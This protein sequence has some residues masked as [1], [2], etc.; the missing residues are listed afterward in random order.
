MGNRAVITTSKVYDPANSTQIGVYLH[1]YGDVKQVA[2][3]LKYCELKGFRTP[4]RDDYGWARL[5]QVIGNHIGGGLS[6]GIGPCCKLD[7]DNGDNGTYLISGWE[8]VGR[9]YISDNDCHGGDLTQMLIEIDKS[10]PEKEQFGKEFFEAEEVPVSELKVGDVVYFGDAVYEKYEK[11]TVVGIG[12]ENINSWMQT[13]GVPYVD[14][15]ADAN[16]DYSKNGNNYIRTATAR[17]VD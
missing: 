1:W 8:I 6:I 16:G 12:K 10:Q 15:Y 4:D 14:K 3:F 17:K 9:K 5:C 13:A 7:C 2:A 11:R